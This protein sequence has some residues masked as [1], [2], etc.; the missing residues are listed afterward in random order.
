M[1]ARSLNK[2]SAFLAI[3]VAG[4]TVI[5][6]HLEEKNTLNFSIKRCS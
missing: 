2:F 1:T 4:N 5:Q 3:R 6:G